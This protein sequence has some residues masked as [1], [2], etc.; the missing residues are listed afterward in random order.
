MKV[1]NSLVGKLSGWKTI[2]AYILVQVPWFNDNPLIADAINK[3][4]VNPEDV[5]AWASLVLQLFLLVGVADILRK[6][7]T[8]GTARQGAKT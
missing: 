5:N 2:L 1:L 6:N 7:V 4:L 8:Q 3:V